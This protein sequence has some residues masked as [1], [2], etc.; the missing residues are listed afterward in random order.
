[1]AICR[2][3]KLPYIIVPGYS[4]TLKEVLRLKHVFCFG[5]PTTEYIALRHEEYRKKLL[6]AKASP[7]DTAAT[8]T[9]EEKYDDYKCS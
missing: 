3:H 2:S 1:M 5:A 6:D 9:E 7:E 8:E 4:S